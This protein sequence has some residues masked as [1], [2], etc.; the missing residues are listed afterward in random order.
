MVTEKN[1]E[2][3]TILLVDD[4]AD[5]R[6]AIRDVLKGE[7]FQVV[8]ASDGKAAVDLLAK[9]PLPALIILDIAMPHMNGWE[10]LFVI[11]QSCRLSGIPVILASGEEPTG[12]EVRPGG[13]VRAFLRKPVDFDVLL[14]AIRR[15]TSVPLAKEDAG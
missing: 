9:D 5:L 7:G 3:P 14:S 11:A 4:H 2:A 10:F 1:I 13:V 6:Q 8:E 15:F 12:S